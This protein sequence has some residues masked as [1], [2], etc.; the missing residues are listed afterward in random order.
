MS[1]GATLASVRRSLRGVRLQRAL[2]S[3]HAQYATPERHKRPRSLAEIP[4]QKQPAA[5][6]AEEYVRRRTA[7][8]SALE[9][10]SIAIFPSSEV[11]F[12]T[13]DV[14][15]LY[16]SDT[17]LA[18]LTGC[19]EIGAVLVLDN[20]AGSRPGVD[21]ECGKSVLFLPAV[22][23]EREQWDG[24]MLGAGSDVRDRFAVDEVA[25]DVELPVFLSK[26]MAEGHVKK[27]YF[28]PS[29]S[30]KASQLVAKLDSTAQTTFLQRWS[31]GVH[32]K[33]FV[34]QSRL[35]KS[36]SEVALLREACRMMAVSFN[37]AMSAT[38]L[39]SSADSHEAPSILPER[40]IEATLEYSCKMLGAER[41]AFP[42][43]VASGPN[44]TILHYMKN[45]RN[46][47]EGDL[48]MVDAGCQLHGYCSDISRT[49][50]I[51][52]RFTRPQRDLYEL[53]LD[54]QK[55]CIDHSRVG[56]LNG[57]RTSMN[58]LHS[59]AS[60][61]LADG[62]LQLG[63]MRGLSLAEAHE[64]GAYATWFN[65]SI[66]HYLG[67]DVHDTHS[68]SKDLP[69]QPGMCIT[70]EPGLYVQSNDE[71]APPEYR[72]IGIR[73]EVSLALAF[74]RG[75]T[76]NESREG[77]PAPKSLI[78]DTQT[79]AS[80]QEGPNNSRLFETGTNDMSAEIDGACDFSSTLLTP[81]S[82]RDRT[83]F[84]FAQTTQ[85]RKF[86]LRRLSRKL[87]TL[88]ALWGLRCSAPSSWG[89]CS[90]LSHRYTGNC[91]TLYGIVLLVR[92]PE[93]P[94]ARNG[95]KTNLFSAN[96]RV[97]CQNGVED[98]GLPHTAVSRPL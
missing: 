73:I 54:V 88:S 78:E 32:P 38:V 94:Q 81:R 25:E 21:S 28:D 18:Y 41:M 77:V 16:H 31:K 51:S 24:P 66:G 52:G 2:S 33:M 89:S 91:E 50:P 14:P 42:C 43:V 35:R 36:E 96:G 39:W 63:F 82:T 17:D 12:M 7:A 79:P 8:L 90:T 46:A 37:E 30:K 19:E 76:P 5:I 34:R 98:P 9:R 1:V 92:R 67:M 58:A 83:I 20:T 44:G 10:G 45:S 47:K 13:E 26:R 72:G 84:S 59:Y 22:D 53:V 68:L 65:H 87:T 74:V 55:Q 85:R 64:S 62:L 40:E 49:W 93:R 29:T 60:K 80:E 56:L 75:K 86:S 15:Y 3:S 11:K 48:V 97:K 61:Q 69:L 27:V 4:R 95:C 71:T 57:K 23:K 70:I 6:S